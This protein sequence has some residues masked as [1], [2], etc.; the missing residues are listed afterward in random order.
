M[1]WSRRQLAPLIALIVVAAV[2]FAV[3]EVI[4]FSAIV[5]CCSRE[6]F[7]NF[8]GFRSE[9]PRSK[10]NFEPK[11]TVACKIG[12]QENQTIKKIPPSAKQQSPADR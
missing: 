4:V 1:P 11:G 12:N 3:T 8:A 2:I 6:N 10:Q 9:Q 5:F 7:E